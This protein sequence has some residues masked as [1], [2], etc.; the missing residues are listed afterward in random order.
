MNTVSTQEII[1]RDV[2]EYMEKLP[3][4]NKIRKFWEAAPEERRPALVDAIAFKLWNISGPHLHKFPTSEVGA[5]LILGKKPADIFPQLTKREASEFCGQCDHQEVIPW[6]WARLVASNKKVEGI[7][8]VTP[9]NTIRVMRWVQDVLSDEERKESFLRRHDPRRF[10]QFIAGQREGIR[11]VDRLDEI[12]PVDLCRSPRKTLESAILRAIENE[13]GGDN[14]LAEDEPWHKH[15]PETVK[16]LLTYSDL[17]Q[18]GIEMDHC[19]ASYASR[20]NEGASIMMPHKDCV[21]I[22]ERLE[23]DAPWNSRRR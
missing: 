21:D 1:E 14:Q 10:P 8:S 17:R 19:A 18:E 9:P 11:I 23:R 13:W 6:Y 3:E 16:V 7:Q 4:T 20:I 22:V 5:N 15:L 2:R 12:E